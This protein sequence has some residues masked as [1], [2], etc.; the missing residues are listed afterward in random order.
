[1]KKQKTLCRSVLRRN[2]CTPLNLPRGVTS[3]PF[4]PCAFRTR[5]RDRFQYNTHQ[6]PTTRAPSASNLLVCDARSVD[7]NI[8]IH[9]KLHTTMQHVAA[10]LR[11]RKGGDYDLSRLLR[12]TRWGAGGGNNSL[13]QGCSVRDIVA[14]MQDPLQR[15]CCF[16]NV[17]GQPRGAVQVMFAPRAGVGVHCAFRL[18]FRARGSGCKWRSITTMAPRRVRAKSMSNPAAYAA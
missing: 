8:N 4:G 6:R 9:M 11:G 17:S 12:R 2:P 10:V 1:M 14:A 5:P 15:G 16:R 7:G 18:L 3:T 13:A